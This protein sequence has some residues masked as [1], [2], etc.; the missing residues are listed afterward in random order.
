MKQKYLIIRLLY[1]RDK[2]IK[3]VRIIYCFYMRMDMAVVGMIGIILYRIL[4]GVLR[5]I[6]IRWICQ[7]L[8]NLK[9]RSLR[10]EH[11]NSGIKVSLYSLWCSYLKY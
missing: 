6:C 5:E 4:W 1:I 8:G 10:L 7:D 11:R 9:G 2:N 3:D